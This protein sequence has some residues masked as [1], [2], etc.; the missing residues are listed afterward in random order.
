MLSQPISEHFTGP[1]NDQKNMDTLQCPN[2][3]TFGKR[4]C[5]QRNVQQPE[6][7]ITYFIT[8]FYFVL[9]RNINNIS[10]SSSTFSSFKHKKDIIHKMSDL[11]D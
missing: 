2:I 5:S 3:G 10:L 11:H 1:Q 9:K 4:S 8:L 7:N 6:G